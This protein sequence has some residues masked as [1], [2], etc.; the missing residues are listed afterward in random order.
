MST[1]DSPT[2][3]SLSAQFSDLR[4]ELKEWE[5]SFTAAHGGRRAGR[6]DIKKSSDIGVFT[7]PLLETSAIQCAAIPNS[8]Y[9]ALKYKTYNRLR[10]II[11][12][13][14]PPDSTASPQSTK[15]H[16]HKRKRTTGESLQEYRE[17]IYTPTRR[18][19][20]DHNLP[21]QL[22]P[23]DSPS[24]LRKLFSPQASS[25]QVPLVQSSIGPTPQRD[26]KVLGL[27][28]M[29]SNSGGSGSHRRRSCGNVST[30]DLLTQSIAAQTPSRTKRMKLS[31][32]N[33]GEDLDEISPAG[34]RHSRT[35][36]S[37]GKRYLLSQFFA[38][39]TKPR[40]GAIAPP[41]IDDESKS[42]DIGSFSSD[43][44]A[45]QP[46]GR[47][48]KGSNTPAFLRRSFSQRI[49]SAV[50]EGDTRVTSPVAIR[51]PPTFSQG[52][53]LS[54]LVQGLR[55]LEDKEL[56]EDMDVLREIE[57]EEQNQQ[58]GSFLATKPQVARSEGSADLDTTKAFEKEAPTKIWRKKGQKRTTKRV[59]MR[60]VRTKPQAVPMVAQ[61]Y[62]SEDEL[63]AIADTQVESPKLGH[64]GES[65]GDHDGLLSGF[66]LQDSSLNGKG[67]TPGYN[68]PGKLPKVKVADK[69]VVKRKVNPEAHANYRS[70]KIRNKNS[71]GNKGRFGR[72]GR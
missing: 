40:C 59:I 6:E 67:I 45:E 31:E 21:S 24:T 49:R 17:H 5:K 60:P 35:P 33:V 3:S 4:T 2:R 27:F 69:K 64:E 68:K 23:Y 54:Q 22:D 66:E 55:D 72:R 30:S 13:R 62:E 8:H 70:L 61:G 50:G 57:A 16:S 41:G 28:D 9:A 48:S 63:S 47:T 32:I 46:N 10:N 56:E 39:P 25:L 42:L 53:S 65:F 11:A 43:E 71:K 51:L 58:E 7:P 1:H 15:S 18:H 44:M 34:R 20:R 26:G 36:A 29:L 52:K 12:G 38:T 14:I 37:T 19:V